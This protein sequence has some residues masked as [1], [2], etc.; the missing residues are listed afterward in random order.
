[1]RLLAKIEQGDVEE[2]KG[3]FDLNFKG[4]MVDNVQANE[5]AV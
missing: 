5:N 2:K 3:V 4:F 1:M